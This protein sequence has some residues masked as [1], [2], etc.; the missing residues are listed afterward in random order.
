MLNFIQAF[1]QLLDSKDNP[2]LVIVS[3]KNPDGDAIGSS[4]GLYHFLKQFKT[5]VQVIVPNDV[6]SFLHWMPDREAIMI[7]EYQT[8]TAQETIKAADAIFCLDFN[9]FHRMGDQ[10][11][12]YVAKFQKIF[13]LIDHHEAPDQFAQHQFSDT[14]YGSTCEMVLDCIVNSGHQTQ[15]NQ[16]IATC[17]YV[18][19]VTD[20]GSFRFPKTRA[21]THKKVSVLLETGIDNPQIHNN[22]FNNNTLNSLQLLGSALN[23]LKQITPKVTMISLSKQA[24]DEHQYQKGDTESIV[25]YGL[26]VKGTLMTAFFI[27]NEAEQIIKISFRSVNDFDVNLFARQHFEGGGHKNAAGGKS[28]LGLEDTLQKFITIV[29]SYPELC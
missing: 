21:T 19:M 24:L 15:L 16:A 23:N 4:L 12:N 26:S 8:K 5:Q 27:E 18:G 25:N 3:H 9:A 29:N 2:K 28:A 14:S 1:K 11:G 13:F 20:S 6:P 17:L 10:M 7:Y 22:L